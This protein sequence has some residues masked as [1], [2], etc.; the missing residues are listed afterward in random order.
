MKTCMAKLELAI[1]KESIAADDQT[2]G[3]RYME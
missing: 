1:G 2:V 3:S